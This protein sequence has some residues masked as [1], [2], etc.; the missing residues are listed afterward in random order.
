MPQRLSRRRHESPPEKGRGRGAGGGDAGCARGPAGVELR[1]A[2][3]GDVVA[4]PG[5]LVDGDPEGAAA[6]PPINYPTGMNLGGDPS[7]GADPCHPRPGSFVVTLST[8]RSRPGPEERDLADLRPRRSACPNQAIMV[9]TA[10]TDTG[11]HCM[12]TFAG[13]GTHRIGNAVIAAAKEARQVMMEVAA[14]KRM[15]STPKT[16]SPTTTGKIQSQGRAGRRRSRPGRP[17]PCRAFQARAYPFPAAAC[18]MKERSFSRSRDRQDG[19][20][21]PARPMP[22]PSP[23][24]RSTTRPAIVRVVSLIRTPTRSA[25]R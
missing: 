24:S 23:M 14:L 11:P 6:L 1:R 15:R 25:G 2:F 20:G 19:P 12:G 8:R 5:R 22:A 21:L 17:R 13:R 4:A 10:D 3:P 18:W 7:P 9:D 16:S